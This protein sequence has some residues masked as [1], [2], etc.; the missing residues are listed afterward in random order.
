MDSL[1]PDGVRTR[2]DMRRYAETL[3]GHCEIEDLLSGTE[4]E[5][6]PLCYLIRVKG[7][8]R[9]DDWEMWPNL[10]NDAMKATVETHRK[11]DIIQVKSTVKRSKNT[12]V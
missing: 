6:Y 5:N 3:F 1:W 2:E 10:I 9:Q 4:F 11:A 8:C 7:A 12:P